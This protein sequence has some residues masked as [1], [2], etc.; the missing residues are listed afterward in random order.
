MEVRTVWNQFLDIE[1]L[2]REFIAFENLF[3]TFEFPRNGYIFVFNIDNEPRLLNREDRKV[4]NTSGTA[5][6]DNP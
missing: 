2:K 3:S 5:Q 1:D 4:G 6:T